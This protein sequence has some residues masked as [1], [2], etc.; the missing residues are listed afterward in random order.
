MD[1]KKAFLAAS[2][3][4]GKFDR[5]ENKLSSRP[6]IHAFVLLNNLVPSTERMISAA[7]HDEYWLDVDMFK[8]SEVATQENI[9]DLSRCRVRYDAKNDCL[10]MFA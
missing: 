6:D 1:F 8:F 2:D 10:T 7:E 4:Y 9:T 5:I 3:E